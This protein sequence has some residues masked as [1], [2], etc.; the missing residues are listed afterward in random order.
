MTKRKASDKASDGRRTV[1]GLRP[2]FAKLFAK[3]NR[4]LLLDISIFIANIFLMRAVTRVFIEVFREVSAENPLAK[5]LL[6]LTCLAMWILPALGAVLKRWHFHQR[7][8]DQGKTV[9]SEETILAGCLFNPLFYFCLNLVITSAVL[10]SLGEFVFGRRLLDNGA[11]FIPLIIIGLILTIIQTYLIYSYFSAPKSPP[12][13]KFLR[14]PQSETLGDICLFLNMIL[15]Q[16]VWNLL[17]FADLGRPSSFLEFAGRLFFL[18]FI[19]LLIYFPPRMFYLAEDISRPRTWLTMLL[20][21]SP[22]IVRV[23]IGTSSNTTPGW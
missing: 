10:T 14:S 11:V 17:T 22:V 1:T 16:V 18:S 8:K 13:S 12:Q 2:W 21:N 7:L 23:L 5:L 4:G 15:F 19:A 3:T 6:G 9:E 20:A